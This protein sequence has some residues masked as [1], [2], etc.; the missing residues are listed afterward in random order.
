MQA[1]RSLLAQAADLQK[2]AVKAGVITLMDAAASLQRR[3]TPDERPARDQLMAD[4]DRLLT[5]MPVE[6]ETRAA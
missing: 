2:V 5:F 1:R 3:L 6:K 4:I